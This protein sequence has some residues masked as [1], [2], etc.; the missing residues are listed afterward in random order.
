M[1]PYLSKIYSARVKSPQARFTDHQKQDFSFLAPTLNCRICRS[2]RIFTLNQPVIKN[3]RH[4]HTSPPYFNRLRK[5]KESLSI[6][7]T[8]FPCKQVSECWSHAP[9]TIQRILQQGRYLTPPGYQI[10]T[11]GLGACF[12]NHHATNY[13]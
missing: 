11:S 3:S 6:C 1:N 5:S 9:G 10:R 8:S 4:S 13:C 2:Y 12:H 7:A